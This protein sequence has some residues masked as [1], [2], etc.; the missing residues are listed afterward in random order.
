MQATQSKHVF[1]GTSQT[2]ARRARAALAQEIGEKVFAHGVC[3]ARLTKD[4]AG[5]F[6]KDGSRTTIDNLNGRLFIG[7]VRPDTIGMDGELLD[8][9][10]SL[11][12]NFARRLCAPVGEKATPEDEEIFSYC[13]RLLLGPT[14]H[15][16]KKGTKDHERKAADDHN[17]KIRKSH[18]TEASA[19][20]RERERRH[21]RG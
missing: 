19:S 16:R 12:A 11:A 5:V 20:I 9:D 17:K 1:R 7:C 10:D 13:E 15:N 18:R 14:Q 8:R 2:E 6:F 4:V 21:V 3:V